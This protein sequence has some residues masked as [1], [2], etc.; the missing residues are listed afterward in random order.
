M[1]SMK[2]TSV[3]GDVYRALNAL[4]DENGW[5]W[6][7][8][9][10]RAAARCAVAVLD[11]RT[12]KTM[13]G[14][15]RVRPPGGVGDFELQVL[16]LLAE[17]LTNGDIAVQLRVD[18]ADVAHAV[19]RLYSALRVQSRVGLVEAGRRRGLLAASGAVV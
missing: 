7:D 15:T 5:D 13:P 12:A 19:R 1:G 6:G 3:E 14:R 11:E 18:V 4:A 9:E 16:R 2:L 8:H 10:V 17:N